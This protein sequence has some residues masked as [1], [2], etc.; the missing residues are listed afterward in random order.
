MFDPQEAQG[1]GIVE[2]VDEEA[3]ELI[4]E[5]AEEILVLD[6]AP[7]PQAALPVWEPTG[8]SQVDAALEELHAIAQA[9][10]SDHADI[11]EQV[12]GSLRATLDGLAAD[13]PA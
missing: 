3:V 7:D 2:A 1:Q 9:D 13:E 10:L 11:Y 4:D 5:Y 6:E 12:Q 8:N